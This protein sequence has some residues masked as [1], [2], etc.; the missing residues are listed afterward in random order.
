M[1]ADQGGQEP[2]TRDETVV[3][4]RVLRFS[5]AAFVI[6]ATVFVVRA[7]WRRLLGLTCS[8]AVV[9]INFLWLEDIVVEVLQPA[10]RVDAWRLGLKTLVRFILFG[11]A[12][13]FAIF[14]VR[15]DALSVL[16]GFSTV[17]L[18]I[19]GEAAYSLILS[20]PDDEDAT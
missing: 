14:I 15:F 17:V 13:S 18:G 19:M 2:R 5:I 12:L 11:V 8:S 16:L 1:S 6:I 10:P 20:L 3:I 4:R 7:E 9:M